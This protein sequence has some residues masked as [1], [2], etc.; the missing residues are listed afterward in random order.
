MHVKEMERERERERKAGG[1][2]EKY[3]NIEGARRLRARGR[4][5]RI[6]QLLH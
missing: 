6:N 5:R 4:G 1:V 3:S 2:D